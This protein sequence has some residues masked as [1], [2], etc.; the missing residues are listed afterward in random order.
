MLLNEF[1]KE[2]RKVQ[3]L[4]ST[5]AKQDATIASQ[6]KDFASALAQQQKQIQLLTVQLKDQATQIQKVSAMLEAADATS[7]TIADNR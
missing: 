2:H 6:Q 3:D 4:Q 5:V 7:K 1:L